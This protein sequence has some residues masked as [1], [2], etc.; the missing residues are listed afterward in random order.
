MTARVLFVESDAPS[1]LMHRRATAEGV[2]QRGCEVHLAAPDAPERGAI[3][4]LGFT[5]H[6]VPFSRGSTSPLGELRTLRALRALYAGL[7]PDLVHHVALKAVLYGTIAA[8]LARVPAIINGVTG[9]GY[10]FTEGDSR[11]GLLRSTFVALARPVLAGANAYTTFEN[12]DDLAA[13]ERLGLVRQGRGVHVPGT[14]VDTRAYRP[15]PE[16]SGVPVVTLASR[17]LWEKGIGVFVEASKILRGEGVPVR[18]VL[19]GLPD[20]ENPRS[21][22]AEQ[23]KAWHDSGIV[24]WWGYRPDMPRVFEASS[25][26]VLPTMYREGVPRVLIEAAACG[27][28][29]V[30][31]DRPGCRDIVRDG[32]NGLLVASNDAAA[33]AGALRR[34]LADPGLR[35]GMGARGRAL[36]EQ[37]FAQEHVLAATL[38]LYE[39]LLP[40]TMG[41][42]RAA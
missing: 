22:P 14:G 32:E 15:S 29:A 21:V 10:L 40:G 5:F 31:T 2:R 7:K 9:L 42:P 20:P 26:V 1:F 28:P 36:V 25:V 35:A 37:R 11:A 18:M 17:M 34:L 8:R 16:P 12:R 33:L 13:F 41:Q 3:E 4:K 30:T 38:D 24:E 6:D 19:V 27:R 39:R 23:L